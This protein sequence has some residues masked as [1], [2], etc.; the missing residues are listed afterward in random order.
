MRVTVFSSQDYDQRFLMAICPDN[1]HFDFQDAK[2]NAQTAVLAKDADVVCV[3]VN[4]SVDKQVI[5]QLLKFDVKHV[6]LRCAGYNNVDIDYAKQ[7]GLLVSRVP[8]YSPQAVAEHTIALIMSLNRKLHKAY[9][10]VKEGNFDLNGLLG[11][12]LCDKTVGVIGTGKIGQAV[13]HILLGFG[14]K[15]ICCDPELTTELEK[16]GCI[17][18]DFDSLVAQSDVITL[19][20][21]LT[22]DTYHMINEVSINNMKTGVMLINTSRG[23]LIDT[24]AAINGIKG[25]KIGYLGLDVYEME[26]D[27]FFKNRSNEIIS[28]DVFQRLLTFPNVMIT[29]HQGFFTQQALEHISQTTIDNLQR[30]AIGDVEHDTFL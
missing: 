14:C 20:C 17:Y 27:L 25:Q 9:N 1:I 30:G 26:E 7:S 29:G 23:K 3:F 5:D 24:K 11:F 28:D 6:A 19:H 2:L 8:A 10:R 4:D 15:V 13:C 16:A 21:P 22:P 12:N 18:T